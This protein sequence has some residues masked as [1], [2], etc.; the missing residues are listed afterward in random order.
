MLTKLRFVAST[1]AD[2]NDPAEG[3]GGHLAPS[4]TERHLRSTGHGSQTF[5]QIV[6]CVSRAT[7]GVSHGRDKITNTAKVLNTNV[8]KS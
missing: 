5:R 6:C 1:K 3:N 7:H 8:V 2:S 4:Y